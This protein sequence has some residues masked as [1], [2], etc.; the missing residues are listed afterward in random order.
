MTHVVLL[1]PFACALKRALEQ[2]AACMRHVSMTPSSPLQLL[3]VSPFR[4]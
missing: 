3:H 2:P 4:A 1:N